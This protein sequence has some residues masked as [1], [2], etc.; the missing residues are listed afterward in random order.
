MNKSK[1]YWSRNFF[2]LEIRIPEIFCLVETLLSYASAATSLYWCI[3]T[4]PSAYVACRLEPCT[5]W[6]QGKK[7]SKTSLTT[8]L[9]KTLWSFPS[10]PI[11]MFKFVWNKFI[12]INCKVQVGMGVT[13]VWLGM[14]VLV[15]SKTCR[16][17][18]QLSSCAWIWYTLTLARKWSRQKLFSFVEL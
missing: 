18:V 9:E 15:G 7:H 12:V 13:L 11:F 3:V 10:Y 5:A 14:V 1:K 4:L 8:Q 16:F 2:L 6:T 17:S